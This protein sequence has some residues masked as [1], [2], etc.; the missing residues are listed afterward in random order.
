M[1]QSMIGFE[2]IVLRTSILF[3]WVIDANQVLIPIVSPILKCIF[4][5]SYFQLGALFGSFLLTMVCFQVFAGW[6]ADISDESDLM[7]LG[8][9]LVFCSCILFTVSSTFYQLILFSMV[10]GIGVSF[11][12]PPSY[13]ALSRATK[14]TR[15]RTKSM[16]FAGASGDVGNFIAFLSTGV[17]AVKFGWKAPF[18]LWG[19][20]SFS[21]LFI[22]LIFLRKCVR[23][24]KTQLDPQ[25]VA[26]PQKEGRINKSQIIFFLIAYFVLGGA[27]RTYVNFSPLFLTEKANISADNASIIF[28]GFIIGGAIGSAVSG[29]LNEKFGMQKTAIG[30]FLLVATFFLSLTHLSIQKQILLLLIIY[31]LSGLMLFAIYPTIYSIASILS[32][33][34]KRGQF[35]GQIMAFSFFGGFVF[36]ILNGKLADLCG[37]TVVYVVGVIICIIG[38]ISTSQLGQ[39]A[40]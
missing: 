18:L 27:Y 24:M 26:L 33:S 13:T 3:H 14:D 7:A 20:I 29:F 2:R 10:Q 19:I 31:L 1:D 36:S 37:I 25:K 4:K 34:T 5:L 16:G 8:M 11:Y 17:L 15:R 21:T 35:Y 28:S 30:E 40:F 32:R 22:Y 6:L 38:T 12:H 23:D 39:K 9:F